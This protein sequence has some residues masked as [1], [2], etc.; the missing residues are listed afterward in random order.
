MVSKHVETYFQK[1][2]PCVFGSVM[3][4]MAG[5]SMNVNAGIFL[6]HFCRNLIFGSNVN[7][8]IVNR[9]ADTICPWYVMLYQDVVNLLIYD[10]SCA[11]A[12][13]TCGAH[14]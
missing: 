12:S 10:I 11:T 5:A 1:P 2:L 9:Q 4:Y 3:D 13:S 6:K 14:V 7:W 8:G